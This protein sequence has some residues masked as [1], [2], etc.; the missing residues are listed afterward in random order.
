M[1]HA[2]QL[3][4]G[5]CSPKGQDLD[6]KPDVMCCLAFFFFFFL[7]CFKCSRVNQQYILLISAPQSSLGFWWHGMWLM[8]VNTVNSFFVVVFCFFVFCFCCCCFFDTLRMW[9]LSAK[10]FVNLLIVRLIQPIWL[11]GWVSPFSFAAPCASLPNLCALSKRITFPN[12][13]ELF[14]DE[15]YTSA[16]LLEHPNKF[17]RSV[18][19]RM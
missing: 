15:R 1:A 7:F 11:A 2:M 16:P 5:Q 3:C 18:C 6:L 10:T 17:S 13:C 4:G 9:G 19:G 12:R 8:F 14:F